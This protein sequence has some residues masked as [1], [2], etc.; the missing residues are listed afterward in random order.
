[1]QMQFGDMV[2][3]ECVDDL[4][5]YDLKCK[6]DIFD[7]SIDY[8][9]NNHWLYGDPSIPPKPRE[10]DTELYKDY[11]PVAGDDC[12]LERMKQIIATDESR[13]TEYETNVLQPW[14]T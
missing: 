12:H 13:N 5:T 4:K 8:W 7:W 11:V 14:R 1:M 9:V 2:V 10:D 3:R 6:R